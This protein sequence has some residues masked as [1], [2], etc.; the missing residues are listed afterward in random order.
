M[1][2]KELKKISDY[3]WDIPESYRQDMQ[4]PGRVFASE[5]ILDDILEDESLEQVI[6]VATLP[7][8]QKYSF[9]MPDIHEGYGAAVG[10]VFATDVSGG[11]ISPGAV[12]YD[13][14]C[15]SG[16]SVVLSDLGFTVPIRKLQSVW[17]ESGVR[18]LNFSRSAVDRAKTVLFL[19]RKSRAVYKVKTASGR[20]IKATGDHPFYSEKGMQQLKNLQV[21]QSSIAVVGF[22]GVPY[23]KPSSAVIISRRN[24][25]KTLAKLGRKRGTNGYNLIVKALERRNLLP[26]TYD[27]PKLPYLLKLMGFMYGDGS[28]NFIGKKQDG[29]VSCF[30]KYADDLML[31]KNDLRIL[32]Y[33]SSKIFQRVKVLDYKGEKRKHISYE[34]Y[35]NSSSLVVLLAALGVPTGTKVK[36]EYRVPRWLFHSPLW[37]KRLFLA[38]F[39]G[40]GL[41]SP[42]RRL[43][44]R[45][46]FNCPVLSMAKRE[47]LLRNGKYFLRDIAKL[48]KEFGVV[49]TR[50]NQRRRFVDKNG[51]ISWLLEL[52]FSSD[53][54]SLVNLWSR[55]GF[56]YNQR[57]SSIAGVASNYLR[58]KD[59]VL[60]EKKD[61]VSKIKGLLKLGW[62]YPMIYRTMG[63]NPLS[64][65]FIQDV[66]TKIKKKRNG[67]NFRI[68][69]TFPDFKGYIDDATKNIWGTG[70][71]WDKI[72]SIEK[73]EDFNDSV[74]DI[75]VDHP[76]HNFIANNFVVSNCGVRVL[77]SGIHFDEIK[78]KTP[79]LTK[80]LYKQVPSGVGRS[81][82]MQLSADELDNVLKN[83]VQALR[84]WNYAT[85][86]DIENCESNGKLPD[87]DPGKV[88]KIAK[89]RGHDQLG[90]MGA[91]NHF[92]EVQRIDKIFDHDTARRLGLFEGGV[93]I[94]I[95]CGSRGLGH[96]V[97]T[98]YIKEMLGAAD[99]YKIT[100]VDKQLAC[101]PFSS[102]EG[103]SYFKAMSSAANFAWANRQMITYLVRRAWRKIFDA[104][105]LEL[106]YDVAHNIAKIE[107]YDGKKVV[108]HRKGATRAFPG[109][110]V[111]IPG[112]MGTASY[113]LV[114]QEGS[115]K[116][117]FGSSCHG[118]G[119]V[120]SRTKAKKT[121][122][123]TDLKKE[124]EEKGISV[125]A[126][127]MAGL[128]EEA[129]LAYKDVEEVVNT[130][131]EIGLAKK[132]A[133]MRPI[134]VIKG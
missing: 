32:G 61:A 62:S 51:G 6:N 37:Q 129:P 57:R 84:E 102:P 91:G 48:T 108:V 4:V 72:V 116:Q 81:G 9:A 14:N 18:V 132:V 49:P 44:K 85:D 52:L 20:E 130:V 66:G 59:R 70:A 39:F 98:D 118:A 92:V 109:Q 36:V 5:K 28:M 60:Q 103:Q 17:Q 38:A 27:H 3:I 110:P 15:I 119:R 8:I 131:H 2:K 56:E 29:I 73:V 22:E 7:G 50:I 35:V 83:G 1:E 97:A 25:E 13:I 24:V 111:L 10:A 88:S 114:G 90:T 41:R 63:G 46:C 67:I 26:L 19:K 23:K 34:F 104:G 47:H 82:E 71:T 122:R 78:D 21:G 127:S 133:R 33:N 42:H 87:A 68:P 134:G 99:K 101:A 65:R 95:H 89:K 113:I 77:K 31:I 58:L 53:T 45:G 105:E 40:A 120:M 123:G 128:A 96:Q 55:I 12:G 54:K 93:V 94:M 30:S 43:G 121:V 74:Y 79:H 124:L 100:L 112:S 117:S 107:E 126:G 75:T 115:L 80:E 86:E 125:A 16:D 106:V 11:A 64:L 69:S 76:D